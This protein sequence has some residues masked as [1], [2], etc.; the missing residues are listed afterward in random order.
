MGAALLMTEDSLLQFFPLGGKKMF[1]I[2]KQWLRRRGR[3]LLR[4][5]QLVSGG[6]LKPSNRRLN[7]HTV[8]C[9]Q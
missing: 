5:S 3:G 4:C 1:K 7:A 8:R 6:A 2:L 9:A